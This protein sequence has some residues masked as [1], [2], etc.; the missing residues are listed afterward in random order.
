M[1]KEN[2]TNLE[3]FEIIAEKKQELEKKDFFQMLLGAEEGLELTIDK[4]SDVF[5]SKYNK[6][7]GCFIDYSFT[8]FEEAYE[9]GIYYN[10][11]VPKTADIDDN[12]NPIYK[13]RLTENMNIFRILGIAVDLDSATEIAV[14]EEFLKINL[15][16]IKFKA[17]AETSY[18]GS[19][20][21][22]PVELINS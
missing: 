1:I 14:T 7:C 3:G 19:F 13:F 4:V 6:G 12:G 21:I 5:K 18:N 20:L 15:T 8:I 10:L 2:N 22:E 16:G 9:I 17:V 11:G